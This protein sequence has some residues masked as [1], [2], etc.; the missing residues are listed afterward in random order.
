MQRV[1]SSLQR[2]MQQGT[3]T[4]NPCLAPPRPARERMR[5]GP[6]PPLCRLSRRKRGST[7]DADQDGQ[8][9]REKAR[10]RSEEAG[11]SKAMDGKAAATAATE[12][13]GS[14]VADSV[15][16]AETTNEAA[17]AAEN[18]ACGA[19]HGAVGRTCQLLSWLMYSYQIRVVDF[20]THLRKLE[21]IHHFDTAY[22]DRCIRYSDFQGDPVYRGC[23]TPP[24]LE[25]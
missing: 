25:I 12:S 22:R 8:D 1:S 7:S 5:A 21:S 13:V 18:S 14:T 15:G 16:A 17:E 20:C 3:R 10:T 9:E 4:R 2:S 23:I 19:R 11:D 24:L 6:A